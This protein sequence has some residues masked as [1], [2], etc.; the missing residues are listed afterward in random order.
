MHSFVF[1]RRHLLLGDNW[2]CHTSGTDQRSL[3]SLHKL[4]CYLP[5]HLQCQWEHPYHEKKVLAAFVQSIH[6]SLMVKWREDR[7]AGRIFLVRKD[8]CWLDEFPKLLCPLHK[9]R[10]SCITHGLLWLDKQQTDA[11]DSCR[12]PWIIWTGNSLHFIPIIREPLQECSRKSQSP[13]Q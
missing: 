12:L 9:Q 10:T 1:L 3:R 5:F 7:R 4:R 2:M 8:H 11:L 6:L 13:H